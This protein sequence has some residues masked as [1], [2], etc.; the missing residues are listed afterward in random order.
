[1]GSGVCYIRANPPLS[2]LP[3]IGRHETNRHDF[4]YYI[5]DT[6]RLHTQLTYITTNRNNLQSPGQAERFLHREKQKTAIQVNKIYHFFCS[7]F[8][9]IVLRNNNFQVVVV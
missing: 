3:G 6:T 5:Y 1:M 9:I 8:R 7:S 4:T 2:S